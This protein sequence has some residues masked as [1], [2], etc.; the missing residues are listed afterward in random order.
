M[1]YKKHLTGKML[2]IMYIKGYKKMYI[3][4]YCD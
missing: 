2:V 4:A 1:S 3:E